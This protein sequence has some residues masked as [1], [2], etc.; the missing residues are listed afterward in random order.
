M[1]RDVESPVREVANALALLAHH[2]EYT[3]LLSPNYG[4]VSKG[5]RVGVEGRTKDK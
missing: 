4:G 5:G 1:E 3:V 2:S